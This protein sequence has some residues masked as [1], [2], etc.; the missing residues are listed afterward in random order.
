MVGISAD[1][2]S[3]VVGAGTALDRCVVSEGS[4]SSTAETDLHRLARRPLHIEPFAAL[5]LGLWELGPLRLAIPVR[6]ARLASRVRPGSALVGSECLKRFLL[7]TFAAGSH[8]SAPR[9]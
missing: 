1:L 7:V 5:P 9:V 8:A 4:C 6:A 2:A 3:R